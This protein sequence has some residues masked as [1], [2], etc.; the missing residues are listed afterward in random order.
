MAMRKSVKAIA[1]SLLLLAVIA[2]MAG[3]GKTYNVSGYV[4]HADSDIGIP[5]VYVIAGDKVAKTDA[6]GAFAITGLSGNA[7]IFCFQESWNFAPNPIEV[8][9]E[10]SGLIIRRI[11]TS[12]TVEPWI[13]FGTH[14]SFAR[15]GDGSI[16]GW[17]S[18]SL[19][20]LGDGTEQTRFVPSPL[21]NFIGAADISS[22]YS[23][24]IIL[25]SSGAVMGCG[26]N[27]LGQVGDGTYDTRTT[28]VFISIDGVKAIATGGAHTI[29]LKNDGSVWAWGF[30]DCGQLGLG[31]SASDIIL[32]FQVSSLSNVVAIAAGEKHSVAVKSDGTVWAWGT[33]YRGQLGNGGT[34][35]E[36][37]PVQVVGIDDAVAVAAGQDHSLVIRSD[38]SLWAWGYNLFGQV[39]D[40]TY[41]NTNK[42]VQ[43]KG[44]S[45]VVAVD[46]GSTFSIALTNDARVWTW[47]SNGAGELG[48][49]AINNS[50]NT[51]GQVSSLENVIKITAGISHAGVIKSDG[52]IWVWGE[53]GD[54][55]LG[56]GDTK[57]RLTPVK[58]LF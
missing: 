58:L 25:L 14:S 3:C 23:H 12:N 44:L 45:N 27:N 43:V 30:N 33:N 49:G 1:L 54:A 41:T 31:V 4:Y 26:L 6:N 28:P 48:D 55:Q 22:S 5:D 11:A 9:S 7:L 10:K 32:P 13:S 15:K 2:S 16:W 50:K 52:S 46:A 29:A 56:L 19:Y 35:N 20:R 34:E 24:T 51:P 53:N 17:G 47:G 8:T 18:N 57:D 21:I 38:G 36:N 39:G 40:G 42:P 37:V